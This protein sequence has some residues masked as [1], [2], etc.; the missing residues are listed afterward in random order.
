MI[1]DR[2]HDIIGAHKTGIECLGVLWGYGPEE[3]LVQ[4][5]ADYIAD[6]PQKAADML[7]G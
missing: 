4:A 2:K 1:G 6:T 7:L 3:E 5:G